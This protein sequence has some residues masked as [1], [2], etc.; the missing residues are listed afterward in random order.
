MKATNLGN[1]EDIL[2]ARIARRWYSGMTLAQFVRETGWPPAVV[3]ERLASPLKKNVVVVAGDRFIC[4]PAVAALKQLVVST[5]ERFHDQH[6]LAP[7]MQQQTLREKLNVDP[8]LLSFALG[9]LHREHR[10]EIK[11]DLVHLAG[12][13]VVMKDEETESRKIIE[14]AFASAGLKVPA[15]K[16]VLVGLRID[17]TRG[18]MIV[19][20]LLRDKTLI[21]VSDDLVFHQSALAGLRQQLLIQ[22]AKSPKIDIA[23]FKDLTGVSRKYAIPLLEYLDRERVTKRVG[24]ERI[25]L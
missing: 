5:L 23:R 22:K 9:E 25:I 7:G 14:Q 15:L 4:F 3:R 20:L 6:S 2:C 17:E 18:Q 11:G 21:K 13:G 12:R 10:L 1:P 19:T 16:D 8:A 24:D